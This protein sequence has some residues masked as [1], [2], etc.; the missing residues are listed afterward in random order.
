MRCPLRSRLL[1]LGVLGL[2][3]LAGVARAYETDQYS[4]RGAAIR[5]SRPALDELVNRTLAEIARD[6]RGAPDPYRFARR[7]YSRLGGVYWVDRIERWAMKSP[8]IDKLP[9]SRYHSIYRGAPVYASRVNFFFGCGRTI[10]IDRTLLGTDKLGHFFSQGLKYYRRHLEGMGEGAL[11]RRGAFNERWIFGQATTSVYSNADL[12]ANYE[13]YLFYRSLFEGGLL[14]GKP[15]IVV[16]HDGRASI[17]RLFDWRDHV[18]DYWDE[19]LNPSHLSPGLQHYFA[20]VLPRFCDEYRR[21]P[22]EFVP[23]GE[24]A[25]AERYHAI[26]MQPAP[27]NRIDS[28]CGAVVARR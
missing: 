8:E 10:R 25:L 2:G 28:V 12:V 15:S 26:D 6:W 1:A 14:D 20:R 19:A 7:V 27:E 4:N 18:N 24:A 21:A 13:G 5:D 3:A 11:L 16:F 9:Q 23:A 17:Q 22:E